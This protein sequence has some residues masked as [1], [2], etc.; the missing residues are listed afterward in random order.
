MKTMDDITKDERFSHI[1]RDA[2]F[3]K[4]PKQQVKV[5]VDKRFESMFHEKK[6]QVQYQVD[7]RGRSVKLGGNENLKKYYEISDSDSDT[8][9]D[10]EEK[11]KT[12]VVD[13]SDATDIPNKNFVKVTDAEKNLLTPD[14]KKKL[15]DL[16]IDYARGEGEIYS[17]S[18]SDEE[19]TDEEGKLK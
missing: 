6:F 12:A 17:D 18:S 1:V 10:E 14:I 13:T 3:R 8:S 16:T 5:K 11:E 19:T 7:K 2:K 9:E 4:L 15:K